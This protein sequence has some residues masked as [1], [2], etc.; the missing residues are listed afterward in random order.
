MAGAAPECAGL[1]RGRAPPPPSARELGSSPRA[2]AGREAGNG[3]L[4]PTPPGIPQSR[5]AS[6]LPAHLSILLRGWRL[7]AARAPGYASPPVP[8]ARES[9]GDSL[10][11]TAQ[12]WVPGGGTGTG[13]GGGGGRAVGAWPSRSSP[14]PDLKLTRSRREPLPRARSLPS[15]PRPLSRPGAPR[16]NRR[17]CTAAVANQTV[18]TALR[19]RLQPDLGKK[20]SKTFPFFFFLSFCKHPLSEIEVGG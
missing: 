18:V 17:L 16:A 13:A 1:E 6:Q 11:P 5:R 4:H 20:S 9:Q 2:P 19:P 15:P 8:G 3:R 12:R 14:A 10:S 7:G